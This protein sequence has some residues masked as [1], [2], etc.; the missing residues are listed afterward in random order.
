MTGN[1]VEVDFSR[2][3]QRL[4]MDPVTLRREIADIKAEIRK[5]EARWLMWERWHRRHLRRQIRHLKAELR[6]AHANG[7]QDADVY[8]TLVKLHADGG[9]P[10]SATEIMAHLLRKPTHAERIR[11]GLALS[12]LASAGMVA[13]IKRDDGRSSFRWVPAPVEAV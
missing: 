7:F 6:A 8:E 2:P 5:E 4:P 12:R 1:L 10:V 13:P 3:E 9:R 11:I